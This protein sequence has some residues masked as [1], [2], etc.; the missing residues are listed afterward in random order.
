M[1]AVIALALAVF[2]TANET[3][4]AQSGT[5]IGIGGNA[6][7]GSFLVGPDGMTLY[8][9]TVDPAGESAC[10]GQCAAN[11]PPLTVAEGEEPTAAAG[12]EGTLDIYVR[13]D[14]SRQVLLDGKPLYYWAFDNAPGDA[15]GHGV[16]NVWFVVSAASDGE[17]LRIGASSLGSTLVGPNG[18]TLYI[19]TVDDPGMSNCY[20]Q[21]ATNWPPLTVPAGTTP[22]AAP[23]VSAGTLGTTARTD[24]TTQVTLDGRPLYYWAFDNEPG[25]ATGHGVN[26][27]WFA[28]NASG[29]QHPFTA[30]TA[31]P[32]TPAATPT[33]TIAAPR[34]PATGT[35]A[36]GE[37]SLPLLAIAAFAAL[38]AAGAGAVTIARTR[39]A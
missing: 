29:Q 36:A 25:D 18:M 32:T 1:L 38:A 20:N 34:P 37:D 8:I 5:T 3:A 12:V 19:F 4:R 6:E 7:L 10:T 21:C 23:G 2:S 27:V 9:F 35:G 30:P 31:T 26:N 11:W 24:G 13:D 33:A 22:T 14:G 15:T 16:N 39:R 17:V 28:L